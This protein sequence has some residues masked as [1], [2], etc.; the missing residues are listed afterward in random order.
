MF[1]SHDD[2]RPVEMLPGIT[3]YTL[4][5]GEAMMLCEITLQKGVSVPLHDH[6]NEQVGYVISGVIELEIR[7][8]VRTLTAGDSYYIPGGVKHMAHAV[9]TTKVIDVFSPP[10]DDYR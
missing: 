10:R 1:I 4:G 5:T 7:G 6:P 3:R 2:V 8:K 9:E